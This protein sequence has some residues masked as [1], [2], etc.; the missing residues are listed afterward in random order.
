MAF[1]QQATLPGIGRVFE[2]SPEAR[3][4][5]LRDNGFVNTKRGNFL[6]ERPLDS[7]HR[8]GLVLKVTVDKDIKTLKISTVTSQGFQAVDVTQLA[9]N[10]MLL[11]KINFIFDGFVDRNCLVEV[12]PA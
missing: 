12:T 11:E 4:Y 6:Y 8:Q 7:S 5:T 10:E 9:N 1:T 2:V 3:P